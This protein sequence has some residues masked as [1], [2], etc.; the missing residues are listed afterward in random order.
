MSPDRIT[1]KLTLAEAGL[2]TVTLGSFSERL[3]VQKKV[4][5]TQL[6]GYDLG[7]RFGW[8][9]RGPYSREL[10]ADA[11]TLK[12]EI[13]A[14]DKDYEQYRLSDEAIQKIAQ[15]QRLWAMPEQL[16]ISAD[17]WLELLTSIHYLKHIAYWPGEPAKGFDLV[18]EKLVAQ[19]PQFQDKN[20]D[21]R[22]TWDRLNEFGL[23]EAKT[24]A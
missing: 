1:L 9:L 12:D 20:A 22:R 13:A 19:K 10:T 15:A 7:Y 3:Q 17:Q 16:T 4:Y 11:F 2:P 24:L 5:L 21:V 14:G 18:F 23:I 8:Y 6:M